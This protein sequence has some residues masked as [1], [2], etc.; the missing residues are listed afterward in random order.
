MAFKKNQKQGIGLFISSIGA[1]I[2]GAT[3]VTNTNNWLWILISAVLIIGGS[4][5]W[6][7]NK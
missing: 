1:L 5:F 4:I 7:L 3:L 2:I 6:F